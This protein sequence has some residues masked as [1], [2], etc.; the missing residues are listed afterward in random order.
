MA[1]TPVPIVDSEKADFLNGAVSAGFIAA[2]FMVSA[3]HD[4][5]ATTSPLKIMV[6][7]ERTSPA[8]FIAREYLHGQGHDWVNEALAELKA[9]LFGA[10]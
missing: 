4:G 6:T 10:P 8:G 3:V 1:V 7:V 2:E 9:S 5:S